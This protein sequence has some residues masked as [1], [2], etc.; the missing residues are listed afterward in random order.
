MNFFQKLKANHALDFL[1][2][3]FSLII[4]VPY[5]VGGFRQLFKLTIISY[6]LY[7]FFSFSQV[8]IDGIINT[9][10]LFVM[11]TS[12]LLYSYYIEEKFETN[13]NKLRII[14]ILLFVLII[15]VFSF[16]F[17]I[18]PLGYEIYDINILRFLVYF[19]ST[20][21]ASHYIFLLKNKSYDYAPYVGL[22]LFIIVLPLPIT[23]PNK[24]DNIEILTKKLTK[25]YPSIK[26]KYYNDQYLFF[27]TKKDVF[28]SNILVRKMDEIFEDKK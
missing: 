15:I 9:F 19:I 17:I 24:I 20:I 1:K 10:K 21:I 18:Q 5:L 26:L 7:P 13:K 25:E 27:E 6:E 14:N 8:V 12:A 22:V 28:G 11:L 3:Y 4:F 2:D 23:L 16:G